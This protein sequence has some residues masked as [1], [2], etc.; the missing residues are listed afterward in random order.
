MVLT[1]PWT[2][3]HASVVPKL[4][5]SIGTPGMVGEVPTKG[6]PFRGPQM[7]QDESGGLMAT[8]GLLWGTDASWGIVADQGRFRISRTPGTESQASV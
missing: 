1:R 8:S 5:V 2:G 3:A 4:R 7:P 6:M